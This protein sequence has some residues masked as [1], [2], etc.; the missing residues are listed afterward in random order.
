MGLLRVSFDCFI[1]HAVRSDLFLFA[2]GGG[3]GVFF[4]TGFCTFGASDLFGV[5]RMSEPSPSRSSDFPSHATWLLSLWRFQ[6]QQPSYFAVIRPGA[7]TL[8]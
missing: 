3:G 6:F 2:K 8:L 4:S 7:A 1:C 5:D